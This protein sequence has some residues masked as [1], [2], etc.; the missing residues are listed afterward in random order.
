M[1]KTISFLMSII[2]ILSLSCSAF[3]TGNPSTEPAIEIYDFDGNLVEN[4]DLDNL[5]KYGGIFN[6][7]GT[8]VELTTRYGPAEYVNSVK[9]LAPGQ[10]WTSYQYKVVQG[11]LLV[12]TGS[13]NEAGVMV[14]AYFADTVG[15]E[16]EL[17]DEKCHELTSIEP[18]S[19]YY[20]Y[21][22]SVTGYINYIYRN[23]ASARRTF[24]V[25]IYTLW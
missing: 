14:E 25:H 2:M 16:R 20:D 8:L 1:K 13:C 7:D 22:G 9:N 5:W 10:Y 3:A 11:S 12:G 21:D 17:M 24:N 15:G 19:E 6:A 4:P 18:P 23:T